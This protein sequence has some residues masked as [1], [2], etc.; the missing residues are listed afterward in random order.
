MISTQ[1]LESMLT[2]L[3][4]SFTEMGDISNVVR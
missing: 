3:A 2:S 1:V 4:P